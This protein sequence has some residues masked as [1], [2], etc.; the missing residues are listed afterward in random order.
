M[1]GQLGNKI[2]TIKK[3]KIIQVNTDENIL[4]VK[5]SVPGKPGNLLSIAAS[6]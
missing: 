4:V 6:E 3:L 1:S 2:T 5:G